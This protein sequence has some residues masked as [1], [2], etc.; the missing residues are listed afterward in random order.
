MPFTPGDCV[1]FGLCGLRVAEPGVPSGLLFIALGLVLYGAAGLVR[2]K[3]ASG[4]R[5]DSA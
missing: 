3:R 4:G 1:L 5:K 2:F